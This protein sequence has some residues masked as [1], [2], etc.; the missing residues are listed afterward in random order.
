MPKDTR[1]YITV[2]NGMP[3]HPK[4]AVLSDSAFRLLV[5]LWCWCDANTTDGK[6]RRAVW[7]RKGR[8]KGRAELLAEGLVY[9]LPD[10]DVQMHDYLEHQRSAK[11]I[12]DLRR[13]RQEAGS[14]GGK[15]KASAMASAKQE[16]EQT[17]SKD[18]AA[19]ALTTDSLTSEGSRPVPAGEV[20]RIV[21]AYVEACQDAGMP[22]PESAQDRVSRSARKLITEG[23][24][25][26]D[27]L[28]AA[29]NA[30]VG[31]WT[32]L[33]TQLQRDAARIAP[34]MNGGQSTTDQRAGAAFRLAD[35]LERKAI[36]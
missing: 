22:A 16:P 7:D 8:A 9:E 24:P 13:V 1:R 34:A 11:E 32:D 5:T 20:P 23:F 31:G 4:I 19:L 15:A 26:G 30:A 17:P 33:A 14:K 21:R 6:V 2:H 12:A 3:D 28:D 25:V 29:R 10:G 27:V 36:G 18:V 35:E